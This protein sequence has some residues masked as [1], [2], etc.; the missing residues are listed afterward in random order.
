M[1]LGMQGNSFLLSSQ[2]QRLIL[3]WTR[4]FLA[5]SALQLLLMSVRRVCAEPWQPCV[6]PRGFAGTNEHSPMLCS[7]LLGRKTSLS[8]EMDAVACSQRPRGRARLSVW[9]PGLQRCLGRC[10]CSKISGGFRGFECH[11][12]AAAPRG[13][14]CS[15]HPSRC[16]C[17]CTLKP[18]QSN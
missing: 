10:F 11:H 15:L 6:S 16:S 12:P 17:K 2:T 4:P 7:P 13:S 14:P 8:R 9:M 3:G 1:L 18:L 5:G